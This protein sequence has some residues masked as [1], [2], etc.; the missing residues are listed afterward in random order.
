[1][2]RQNIKKMI[3]CLMTVILCVTTC[4]P[5]F[6][7]IGDRTLLHFTGEEAA[8]DIYIEGASRMGDGFYIWYREGSMNQQHIIL[9]YA[10]AKAEPEKFILQDDMSAGEGDIVSVETEPATETDL[11]AAENAAA[12]EEAAAGSAI[13]EGEEAPAGDGLMAGEDFIAGEGITEGEAFTAEADEYIDYS[14]MS[15]TY[16]YVNSMFGWKDD[17]Y[18]LVVR[19]EYKG[20]ESKQDLFVKH[21]R[22]EDGKAVP[23][24]CDVPELDITSLMHDS[25]Y[26]GSYFGGVSN[27][28]MDG[29]NLVGTS[30]TDEGTVLVAF[31]LTTG[32]CSEFAVEEPNGITAGPEGSVLINHYDYDDSDYSSKAVVIRV[33]LEDQSEEQVMELK[34]GDVYNLN[35]CYDQEKDVLYYTLEGELWAAPHMDKEQAFSVN[36][37]PEAGNGAICL[38]DGFLLIWTNNTALIRNTDPAQRSAITLRADLDSWNTAATDA[39][40]AMSEVR[41]DVAV[42]LKGIEDEN[43]DMMQAMMN[44]DSYMDI[45][46]IF[47][48]GTD[49]NALK[50][51]GFLQDL[52][53][54]EQIAADTERMYPVI[55]DFVKQ[56]G[57][58]IGVPLYVSAGTLGINTRLWKNM[59]G[60]EEELPKTWDQFFDWLETL[61]EKLTE[62]IDL[63]EDSQWMDRDS[64]R[65]SIRDD[66]MEQY[67]AMMDARGEEDYVF[68]TPMINSLLK[69]LEE[70]DYDALGVREADESKEDNTYDM[71]MDKK[72]LLQIYFSNTP[73]DHYATLYSPLLLTFEEGEEPIIP[74][75]MSLAILNPYSE[76]PEEAKQYLSL[77]LKNMS[78]SDAC[79]LFTDKTEPIA[80]SYYLENKKSFD[81]YAAFIQEEIE[82]ADGDDKAAW[83]ANLREMEEQLE[84]MERW[85][86]VV[87]PQ[88]IENYKAAGPM[89]KIL[90][91]G[92]MEEIIGSMDGD[93]QENFYQELDREKDVDKF[94]NT[95]DSKLQMVRRE[96]H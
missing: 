7:S 19:T 41:G 89:M 14:N 23:E 49:Y 4:V 65:S 9:R 74:A 11:P 17:L 30:Y 46:Q 18:A 75:Y 71:D 79:T 93:A 2:N 36:E 5:A 15:Y 45:Y 39:V 20:E 10:D 73:G 25:D 51:R 55:R 35:L 57:K 29:D 70:V 31:D 72:T 32:F 69:R 47:C 44:R 92:Y 8:N 77:M 95:I 59:G 90:T 87:S 40:Y 26:G 6:A 48:S 27:P 38:K 82:K 21:I 88:S 58:I 85:G 81:E 76:H 37:C 84:D 67:Q 22:L 28:I 1:M 83:E 34:G 66:I 53:D 63:V 24:D 3:L 56:D 52:S 91:H 62:D 68:N 43:F 94:L 60:T 12:V 64:F 42:L 54:N 80:E 78:P 50:S 86:W 96:G 61:P 33:G 16:E 13:P